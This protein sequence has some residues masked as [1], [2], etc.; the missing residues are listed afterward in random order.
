MV[1]IFLDTL[2]IFWGA[3]IFSFVFVVLKAIFK[4]TEFKLKIEIEPQL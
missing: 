4:T 1:Y 2:K 3:L